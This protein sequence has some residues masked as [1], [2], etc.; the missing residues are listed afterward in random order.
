MV[1]KMNASNQQIVELA[2]RGFTETQIESALDLPTGSAAHALTKDADAMKAVRLNSL[3]DSFKSLQETAMEALKMNLF[4]E[5][6]NVRQRAVELIVKQGFGLL[7]PKERVTINNNIHFLIER[8]E[9]A[10]QIRDATI[11]DV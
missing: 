3:E 1:G 2:R 6:D 10:K 11:T 7:K 9:K 5:N 4:S 8:A